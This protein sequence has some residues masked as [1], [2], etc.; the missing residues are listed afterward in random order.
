MDGGRAN[1]RCSPEPEGSRTPGA[2]ESTPL[3]ATAV[4]GD[5]GWFEVALPPGRY[6]L[7]VREAQGLYANRVNEAGVMA[8]VEVVAGAVARAQLDVDHASVH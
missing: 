7:F 1:A 2:G 6:S 8:A 4:S 3:V 5:D